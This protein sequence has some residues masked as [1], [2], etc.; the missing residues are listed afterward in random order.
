MS[1]KFKPGDEVRC[2]D[3][4]HLDDL[5][6][7]RI[8][9]ILNSESGYVYIKNDENINSHYFDYRFVL[10]KT[11]M[12]KPHKHAELIKAWADGAEI[13][14]KSSDDEGWV[15]TSKPVWSL[16]CQYRI[17]PEVKPDIVR[18]GVTFL[19]SS[20]STKTIWYDI[21]D[22]SSNIKATWKHD[23]EKYNLDSIEVIK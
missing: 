8:Y 16:T 9:T 7:D 15:F 4:S 1:E 5:T 10:A 22:K 18:Y 12:K 21:N 13:E 17:K 19:D 11:N 6:K 14:Y 23:G 20:G 3:N 2:I